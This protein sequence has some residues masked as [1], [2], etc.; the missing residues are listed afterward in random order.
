MERPNKNRVCYEAVFVCVCVCV[1]CALC[2]Y[3]AYVNMG[4]RTLHE[5]AAHVLT[6]SHT[7][8]HTHTLL[9]YYSSALSVVCLTFLS[10]VPLNQDLK[11]S[12]V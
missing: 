12:V 9:F 8:T 2:K 4:V 1:A 3:T 6:G 10:L 11:T 5:A 7:H